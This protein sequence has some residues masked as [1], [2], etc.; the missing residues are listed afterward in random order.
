MNDLME[1]FEKARKGILRNR[2]EEGW[3]NKLVN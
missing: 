3:V 1:Q 2:K